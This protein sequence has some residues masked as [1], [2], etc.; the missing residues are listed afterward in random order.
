[1]P[2]ERTFDDFAVVDENRVAFE[3]ARRLAAGEAP[4]YSPLVIVGGTG[5]GKSHLLEAMEHV[6]LTRFQPSE[7]IRVTAEDFTRQY[8]HAIERRELDPFRDS[9]HNAEALLIDDV[10]RLA[11][12][13]GIAEALR[14][15]LDTLRKDGGV[16]AMS[17]NLPLAELP[18]FD[19]RF[20]SRLSEG[21]AVEMGMPD[22]AGRE[23]IVHMWTAD[24][25]DRLDDQVVRIL[26]EMSYR[27][28]RQM[29][30]TLIRVQ[31]WS[32]LAR[33]PLT[34]ENI[35]GVLGSVGLVP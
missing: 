33:R 26:A 35:E 13:E 27:D 34:A 1:M 12:R 17:S 29:W 20:I 25:I 2:E 28:L 30:G 3:A 4:Q 15:A 10:D 14:Y 16:I 22:A 32:Q 23:A 31:T 11:H 7:V 19:P 18:G 5:R 24:R 8:V 21:L 6:L 9:Y